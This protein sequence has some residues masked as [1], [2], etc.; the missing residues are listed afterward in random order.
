MDVGNLRYSVSATLLT[1]QIFVCYFFNVH[2][3]ENLMMIDVVT[4]WLAGPG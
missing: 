3:Y 2:I 4:A 1:E